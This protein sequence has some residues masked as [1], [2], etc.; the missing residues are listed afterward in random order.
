MRIE[1]ICRHCRQKVGQLNQPHWTM[2]DVDVR[3]G[4]GRLTPAE[5][6]E[7]VQMDT[8]DDMRVYTVCSY[9]EN[10]LREHPELLLEGKLLQ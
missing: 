10:A 1:Y 2:A 7:S 6:L 3:L 4:L 8:Y 9:C 5:R